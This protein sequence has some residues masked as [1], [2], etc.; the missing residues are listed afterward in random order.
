MRGPTR[1]PVWQILEKL[2]VFTPLTPF[3]FI[4][5]GF[6]EDALLGNELDRPHKDLDLLA[7]PGTLAAI[8]AQLEAVQSGGWE[9]VLAGASGQPLMLRGQAGSLELEIYQTVPDAD[10]FS[11]EVPAQGPASRLRLFLPEDT[12]AYPATVLD[13]L[14]IQTVSPLALALMRASSA[15]TRHGAAAGKRARDLAMLARL[16]ETFLS[17][18]DEAQLQ[19]RIE[20]V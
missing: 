7:R 16:R 6:A 13:G 8:T 9:V 3:V 15:Q 5:G 12:F 1:S 17:A 18:Y 19:P 11:F 10:G 2:A 14:A 4:M 20:A